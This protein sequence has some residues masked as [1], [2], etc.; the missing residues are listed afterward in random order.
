M[1]AEGRE[2][3]AQPPKPVPEFG[4]DF[5][6]IYPLRTLV[7]EDNPINQKIIWRMLTKLGYELNLAENGQEAVRRFR[8]VGH[9]LILMDIQMPV[10]DGIGATRVIGAQTDAPQPFIVALTANAPRRTHGWDRGGFEPLPHQ[11]DRHG[12][13]ETRPD[14]SSCPPHYCRLICLTGDWSSP[15]PA[16]SFGGASCAP[17]SGRE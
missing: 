14:R 17:T 6:R 16:Q 12:R 2:E 4:S 13:V 11:A 15:R 10:R 5:A 9:D 8:D 1:L 7:V 3:N